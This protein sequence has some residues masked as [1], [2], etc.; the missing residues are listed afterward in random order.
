MVAFLARVASATLTPCAEPPFSD[1]AVDHPFCAEIA[2][3][4]ANNV[5]LGFEDGTFQ[6]SGLVTRQAMSAFLYRTA[7]LL[8]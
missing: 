8:P 7:A 1:V 6:P 5:T 4:K 2:W 3:A